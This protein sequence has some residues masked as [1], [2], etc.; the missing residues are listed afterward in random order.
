[1]QKRLLTIES[2]PLAMLYSDIKCKLYKNQWLFVCDVVHKRAG[3]CC[4]F[5]NSKNNPQVHI[6][7][8]F[9]KQSKI[10]TIDSMS[11]LCQDC[12]L[13]KQVPIYAKRIHPNVFER[14]KKINDWQD[15]DVFSYFNQTMDHHKQYATIIWTPDI[16]KQYSW[17]CSK[18]P[19]G[20]D[21]LK[22]EQQINDKKLQILGYMQKDTPAYLLGRLFN[23]FEQSGFRDD[24]IY[25]ELDS[26]NN[27]LYKLADGFTEPKNQLSFRQVSDLMI[28]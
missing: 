26:L 6:S 22:L 4:E 13:V 2:M 12:I 21:F 8:K 28:D 20:L 17:I 10:A 18:A 27:L 23:N 25:K 1:M 14:L 15:D 9:D 5:C 7:W 16:E 24:N 11:L 3:G 19:I